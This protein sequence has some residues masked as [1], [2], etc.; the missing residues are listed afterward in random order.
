LRFRIQKSIKIIKQ[1][2]KEGMS[3]AE[4]KSSIH[5]FSLEQKVEVILT[6]HP[7]KMHRIPR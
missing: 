2:Q 5:D 6:A 1:K 4:A 7:T 3:I